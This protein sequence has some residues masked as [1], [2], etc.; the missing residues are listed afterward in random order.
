ML[1]QKSQS[2]VY[3]GLIFLILLIVIPYFIAGLSGIV[4]ALIFAVPFTAIAAIVLLLW[5]IPLLAHLQTQSP[6]LSL[7]LKTLMMGIVLVAFFIFISMVSI[8]PY[9]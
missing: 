1:L 2:R 7:I 9:F 4:I 6:T 8:Q 5:R 3:I